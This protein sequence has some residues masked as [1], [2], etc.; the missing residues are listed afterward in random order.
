MFVVRPPLLQRKGVAT[1]KEERRK[2][3]WLNSQRPAANQ[4]LG[5]HIL[6]I[7]LLFEGPITH[8]VNQTNRLSYV[9]ISRLSLKHSAG[10]DWLY[11]LGQARCGRFSPLTK[12][13]AEHQDLN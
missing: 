2:L 10:R 8:F 4:A 13:G 9:N 3:A 11:H 7:T 6:L 1:C 12:V 5:K